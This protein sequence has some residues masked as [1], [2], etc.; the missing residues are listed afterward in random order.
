MSLKRKKF[1]DRQLIKPAVKKYKSM[2]QPF[3]TEDGLD[4][5]LKRGPRDSW[6]TQLLR[7]SGLFSFMKDL[8]IGKRTAEDII[9]NNI[10]LLIFNPIRQLSLYKTWWLTKYNQHPFDFTDFK[11]FSNIGNSPAGCIVK[12][13]DFTPCPN[14]AVI[15]NSYGGNVFCAEHC[16]LFFQNQ[17]RKYNFLV[18]V[19]NIPVAV[20]DIITSYHDPNIW[21]QVQKEDDTLLETDCQHILNY[22]SRVITICEHCFKEKNCLS[23][24]SKG[25]P[26]FIQSSNA[27][28]NT[29]YKYLCSTRCAWQHMLKNAFT[30]DQPNSVLLPCT[31][32]AKESSRDSLLMKIMSQKLEVANATTDTGFVIQDLYA[33]HHYELEF[34][35]KIYAVCHDNNCCT[36]KMYRV[37]LSCIS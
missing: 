9:E 14:V 26:L 31:H 17:L 8:E 16:Q 29:V 22:N 19:L 35:Q 30:D 11:D 36:G 1:N 5:D 28:E 6:H 13:F 27:L 15:K 2:L 33:E 21:K 3:F 18:D 24:N 32:L 4:C 20:I 23:F 10:E 37:K 25:F 7:F 12:N 34:H